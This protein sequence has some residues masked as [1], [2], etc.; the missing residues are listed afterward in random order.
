[1]TS[2][3]PDAAGDDQPRLPA[4]RKAQLAAYVA[5]VEQVTVAAL[6]AKF[7]VSA[8]TIRRDLDQLD[9]DG[10]V[11]RTHGG[12]VSPTAM[13]A[14]EQKLDIRLQLQTSAKEKI[15]ALAATL[16][17]NGSVVM[18]NAG[19]TTLALARH[20]GDHR[21]LTIA[22]NNLRIPAEISDRACRDLY[23][24]GGAVRLRGQATVGPVSFQLGAGNT[25]L[26]LR[27]DVAVV[28]VGAVSA[29]GGFSTSNLAEAAMM[30]EMIS[31]ATRVVIL[32]D[33]TK[34]DRTL[35]AQVAELGRAD[36][37]VTDAAPPVELAAALEKAG[38]RVILPGDEVGSLP[39]IH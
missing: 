30:G 21:E 32:A 26:D 4:G 16:I 14:V 37:L 35:F 24:F 5:E 38:V 13:R 39:R 18:I 31:R 1:M 17:E 6:S 11:V 7:N 19:T 36:F 8:D 28:S 25:E 22:T 27:C 33:S 20:L 12:A 2:T 15:G 3:T 29:D 34:F 9:A 23:L 10:L